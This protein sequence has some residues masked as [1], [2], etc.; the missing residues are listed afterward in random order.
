MHINQLL[1]PIKYSKDI[2]LEKRKIHKYLR[3]L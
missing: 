3:L 2:V 1:T